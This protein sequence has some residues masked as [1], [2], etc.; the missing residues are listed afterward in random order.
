MSEPN[1]R[2][3]NQVGS[4]REPRSLA[5][6]GIL[7]GRRGGGMG[8]GRSTSRERCRNSPP[9]SRRSPS[10]GGHGGWADARRGVVR[11]GGGVGNG[12]GAMSLSTC[13][14]PARR[15]IRG[16]GWPGCGPEAGEWAGADRRRG[17]DAG[18]PHRCRGAVHPQAATG[19]GPTL[20]A[21]WC[22]AGAA[23]GRA[24]AWSRSLR[25]DGSRNTGV[26]T[27]C[28]APGRGGQPVPSAAL[29]PCTRRAKARRGRRLPRAAR[30]KSL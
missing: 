13:A 25:L 14:L 23:W 10:P 19:D 7:G 28:C 29:S 8:G 20:G 21:E 24:W 3:T 2:K 15:W 6:G 5:P 11:R 12:V 27:R 30:A 26:W 9:L 16:G 22:A 4:D 17:S 18:I 1:E